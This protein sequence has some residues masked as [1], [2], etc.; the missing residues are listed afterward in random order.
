GPLDADAGDPAVGIAVGIVVLEGHRGVGQRARTSAVTTGEIVDAKDVLDAHRTVAEQRDT[1]GIG[2]AGCPPGVHDRRRH[3][4][5]LGP[6]GAALVFLVSGLA[7]FLVARAAIA[8]GDG[9]QQAET[10]AEEQSEGALHERTLGSGLGIGQTV[11]ARTSVR[12][13]PW[14]AICAFGR[15]RGKPEKLRLPGSSRRA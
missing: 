9:G 3:P 15:S 10:K 8:G 1:V 14:R 11:K 4:V 7:V 12:S 2:G 5:L 6:L 13:G